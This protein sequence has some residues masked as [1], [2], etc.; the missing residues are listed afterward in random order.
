[1]LTIVCWKWRS[2]TYRHEYTAE[3]VNV[4]ASMLRRTVSIPHRLVCVTDDPAGVECETFP[5]WSD[6]DKL[7]NPSSP[8][9]PNCYRRL[10]I[11][12][13]A[14][15]AEMGIEPGTRIA[16]LDLDVVLLG[17]ATPLFSRQS[18]FV[19]WQVKGT[20]NAVC[21]QGTY[22]Q[23]TA[24]E[25]SWLW[26]EFDP[27]VSPERTRRARYLGSDQAWMSYRLAG[28]FHGMMA[29]HGIRSY[30]REMMLH[31]RAI[32]GTK[33]VVFHGRLKPWSPEIKRRSPWVLEH[34]R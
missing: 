12:D 9:L 34:W 8:H 23:F 32:L 17:D 1:M 6:C 11:F 5:L 25:F 2:A 15:Q 22:W 13:E 16:S 31:R 26:H 20:H 33:M 4:L 30:P 21:M 10:K 29:A 27:A 28:E 24:G 19:S 3:H 7:D 14:T 18:G